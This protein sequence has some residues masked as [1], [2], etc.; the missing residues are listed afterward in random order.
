M[1]FCQNNSISDK[2]SHDSVKL[3]VKNIEK[4]FEDL[5]VIKD[6]SLY[7]KE[8]AIIRYLRFAPPPI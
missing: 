5:M 2:C 3:L 6:V 8:N 1:N 7:M 4:S